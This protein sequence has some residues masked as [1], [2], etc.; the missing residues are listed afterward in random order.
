MIRKQRIETT[1]ENWVDTKVTRGELYVVNDELRLDH[2]GYTY[3]VEAQPVVCKDDFG[4]FY[5]VR[6]YM[7]KD[8]HAIAQ[9]TR[10]GTDRMWEAHDGDTISH[11]YIMRQ[12]KDPIAAIL[13]VLCAVV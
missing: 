6:V 2:N 4:G 13:K 8:E 9:A 5:R 7:G 12:H 1:P 10:W 11:A 3:R